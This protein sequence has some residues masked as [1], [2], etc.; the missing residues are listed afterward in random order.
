MLGFIMKLQK[1]TNQRE[2]YAE[3]HLKKATDPGHYLNSDHSFT[4]EL[5]QAI[6]RTVPARSR[7]LEIGCGGGH[8]AAKLASYGYQVTAIDF[9]SVAVEHAKK[10]YGESVRFIEGDAC[11]LN[12]S[13]NSFDAVISVD[14]IEHLFDLDLHLKE[15]K[16]VLVNKGVYIF[17]TPN[18]IW[19]DLYYWQKPEAKNFHPSVMTAWQI[20]K[21]LRSH[22]YFATFIKH[23]VLPD[24]QLQKLAK[25]KLLGAFAQKMKKVPLKIVPVWLQPSLICLA[26]KD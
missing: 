24:Y 15:V 3:N 8:A 7:I 18:K 2:F 16:R 26:T 23:K 5:L 9:S 6:L 14:L 13:T 10:R 19:N 12:F 11:K 25:I 17:K 22:G 4:E 20:K 1:Q 21:L